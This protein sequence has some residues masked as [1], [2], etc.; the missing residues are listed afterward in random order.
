MIRR[1]EVYN[2]LVETASQQQALVLVVSYNANNRSKLPTVHVLAV[3]PRQQ[4]E[5]TELDVT[6]ELAGASFSVT[7]RT[8]AGMPKKDLAEGPVKVLE[9]SLMRQVDALIARYLALSPA[10]PKAS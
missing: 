9:A 3:V 1:G 2:T 10:A 5:A 6:F 8:L 4:D 7:P